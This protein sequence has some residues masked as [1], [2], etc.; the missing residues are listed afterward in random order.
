MS[1]I[2]GIS[3]F[4][5]GA[6]RAFS[7]GVRPYVI[8]PALASLI[9]IGSGLYWAFS[10]ITDLAV[11]LREALPAWLEF[12]NWILEPLLY[13]MGILLGAWLFG[14]IA[15][16][17]GA[18]FLGELSLR[19]DTIS[20]PE[21]KWWQQIL[22]TL[23]REGRKLLYQLP[24]LFVLIVVSII[25]IVNATAPFLWLTYGAWMVAVQFC[26]YAYENRG[27]PFTDTL[28]LL[29]KYRLAVIGFGA[30][31]TIGMSIPF[32]NFAIAPIA[33]VGATLLMRDLIARD[34]A[35]DLAQANQ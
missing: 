14:F 12:L 30:C 4:L 15:T 24:R 10:Y 20:G 17:L 21:L 34:M 32:L 1:P 7:P 28:K 33:V 29:R 31:A 2:D 16:V 3:Y 11:Y 6:D 9:V 22:P 35:N 25:P 26:D 19:V 5:K 13:L 8:L 27:L 23:A 18:P